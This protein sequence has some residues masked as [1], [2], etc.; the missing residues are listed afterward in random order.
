MHAD[1]PHDAD[2]VPAFRAGAAGDGLVPCPSVVARMEHGL[3][4]RDARREVM[5]ELVDELEAADRAIAAAH[6]RRIRAIEAVRVLAVETVRGLDPTL[7]PVDPA[8]VVRVS[9]IR[10]QQALSSRAVRVEV[11]GVLRTPEGTTTSLVRE[12]QVL[13]DQHP[14][15]V[16]ALTC[17]DISYAHAGAVLES[18]AALEPDACRDLEATL[19]ER[20]KGSTVAALRRYARRERERSHPRPLV[21][22]H[23]ERL[24]DRHI[25]LEPARDGMMWL[26]QY[27][28]AVQATAIYN[29]LTDIAVTFQSSGEDRTLAQLRV[30]VFSALLL[31]DEAPRLVHEGPGRGAG[32]AGRGVSAETGTGVSRAPKATGAGLDVGET[33]PGVAGMV[34][35]IAG[36]LPGAA[37][38]GLGEG[39]APSCGTAA[40]ST[41]GRSAL[42]AAG[43]VVDAERRAPGLSL[44]G[45]R[46]TVAVTVPVMTLLGH[47]DEPGHLEGYGPVDAD[48]AREIAA[49][50]PSFTRVLTHPE[51]AVVLSVG[52]QRYAVPSDLKTW[53]RLRDETCRFPGC[54][55]RAARCDIDHVAPW[56]LGGGT[57]HDNLIHLC[58]HHHRLKHETGWSVASATSEDT[59][60][61]VFARPEAVV[62]TSPAGRQY[63]DH[64][65]LPRPPHDV[66]RRPA[67]STAPGEEGSGMSGPGAGPFPEEPPF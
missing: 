48:T 40:A 28:P 23:R 60:S 19:V 56:R 3:S 57:D 29:R 6:A 16:A 33:V 55:R 37:E 45:V 25:E 10:T 49:R 63:V 59:G 34:P 27:L 36:V 39:E 22:R 17:G 53:L 67:A 66:L 42:S 20:A 24:A 8:D 41:A 21:E 38:A 1:A 51:T 26:H 44:R 5:S 64:P 13:V 12:A 15:T 11:A 14:A 30:D 18:T 47:G 65:A 9:E 35:G 43:A 46:P 62:W 61:G 7:G 54:S 50:A 52:R 2:L 4:W 58:R 31:D 32:A